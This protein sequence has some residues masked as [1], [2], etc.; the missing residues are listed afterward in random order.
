MFFEG[1]QNKL[2]IVNIRVY[3]LPVYY[4]LPVFVLV[5]TIGTHMYRN[6]S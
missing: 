4:L 6:S 1:W 2:V 5:M 3:V